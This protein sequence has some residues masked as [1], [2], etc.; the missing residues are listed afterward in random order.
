MFFDGST[1]NRSWCLCRSRYHLQ[2]CVFVCIFLLVDWLWF[3]QNCISYYL[4]LYVRT[5]IHTYID[6]SFI[7]SCWVLLSTNPVV[8]SFISTHFIEN[9][10]CRIFDI[11]NHSH[12]TFFFTHQRIPQHLYWHTHTN[13]N[14]LLNNKTQYNKVILKRF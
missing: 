4:N 6:I 8:I 3:K 12:R 2:L 9:N 10:P 5:Y 13:W 7:V 14:H 1:S 11:W